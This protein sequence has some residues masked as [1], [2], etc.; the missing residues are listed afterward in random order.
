VS[1]RIEADRPGFTLVELLVVMAVIGILVG[2]LLPA[3]Q[4]ARET[5]RR[6]QCANNLRQLG[7]AMLNYENTYRRLPASTILDLSVTTTTNNLAWGVH[8]RILLFLEQHALYQEVDITQPW[9]YQ[10]AIDALQV[11]VF[12]CPSDPEAR[13]LRDPGGGR[14]RLYSTTYGFNMGTWF[15]YHPPTRQ[16]GDGMFY[17]NSHLSL[18]AVLDGTSNTLLAS[19][20]RAWQPYTRNGGPSTTEIP[21]TP[22]AAAAIVLSGPDFKDTGHTEWPDG[23]VHHTG[24]TATLPP[25]TRVSVSIDGRTMDA[26]FNSWQEGRNGNMGNATYAIITS[27]SF[28]PGVVQ[29]VFVD[30]SVRSVAETI[31]R[32]IWR[33]L[34]TRAG[35]E[36]IPNF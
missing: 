29:S 1:Y 8:G 35:R 23:R 30:G 31:Q 2:V 36:V 27:R 11:S 34:A 3:V 10:P 32:D 19:E 4:A 9:D 21:D 28:H 25:N 26:D 15:V 33:A 7:L 12:R 18:S 5:A 13:R 24:F 16:G 14:S 20:V 17:P 22:E 6:A